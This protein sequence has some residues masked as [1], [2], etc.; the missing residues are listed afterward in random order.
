MG[1]PRC[2]DEEFMRLFNELGAKK[3]AD[4]LN[5]RERNVYQRR[6]DIEVRYSVTIPSPDD[7]KS[8]HLNYPG[9][10][11][12][13]IKNGIVLVGG[14]FH[15]WPDRESTCM[16][17]FKKF[18]SD[19]KPDVVILNGDVMD[20]PKISRHPQNWEK[21][22]D[23]WEELE[24]AQDY[25]N[26]I[27]QRC[28]RGAQKIWTI[29]NHDSRFESL[30][31][32]SAPQMK[33]VRGVHLSDHFPVWQKA[34]S[35]MINYDIEPGR[36]MVKHIPVGS[37]KHATYNNVKAA[38]THMV[39]NHLHSQNIRAV[40]DYR[41]FD[42]YGVD[43]GCIADKYENAF[44]YTQNSPVDWRSGFALLTYLQG[45]LMYPELITKWT[46]QSVYFRGKLIQV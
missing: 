1:A 27:V 39:T 18:V 41:S 9:C 38:G 28:K 23:V 13:N 33:K 6:K 37:G 43:T 35:C 5:L 25:L 31:A 8:I 36:T 3:L 44:G 20:F 42:L 17:A 22:P 4:R 40:T 45:R 30:M 16:R 12:L 2:S 26:D 32:N 11:N 19:L 14:D 29:G 7:K 10:V 24:A 46:D 21:A 34:M 15:I